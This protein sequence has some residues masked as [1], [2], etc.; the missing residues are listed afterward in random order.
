MSNCV[1]NS[2]PWYDQEFRI[3]YVVLDNLRPCTL[4][5]WPLSQVKTCQDVHPKCLNM[6]VTHRTK[7]CDPYYYCGREIY[8][9]RTRTE[10]WG[11][12]ISVPRLSFCVD[13]IY[14]ST[15]LHKV[16]VVGFRMR[17]THAYALVPRKRIE[18]QCLELGYI[19]NAAGRR[20]DMHKVCLPKCSNIAQWYWF[21]CSGSQVS[22]TNF[23][24]LCFLYMKYFYLER[25][26]R[27]STQSPW[28]WRSGTSNALEWHP[29]PEIF[30][31][32]CGPWGSFY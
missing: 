8:S 23:N 7:Q 32:I 30:A 24:G 26:T 31:S 6:C 5:V 14:H 9:I 18:I 29:S 13:R 17:I 27:F 1:F 3:E 25:Y 21:H 10:L 20:V 12:V 4:E 16:W 28:I 19:N 11:S 2:H 22:S 15:A